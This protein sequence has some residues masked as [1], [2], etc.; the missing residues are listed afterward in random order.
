MTC[1]CETLIRRD[2]VLTTV[3]ASS[4]LAIHWH[5]RNAY[6]LE[7][8]RSFHVDAHGRKH[9]GKLFFAFLLPILQPTN[10]T[11]TSDFVDRL[12]CTCCMAHTC[13]MPEPMSDV[14]NYVSAVGTGN[15]CQTIAAVQW[16][17]PC[18]QF[19]EDLAV[20]QPKS[21]MNLASF[22]ASGCSSL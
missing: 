4:T 1:L 13:E 11:S 19:I 5:T 8:M 10:G 3:L 2:A 21:T 15:S 18:G 12:P 9:N 20:C 6:L 14:S 7:I 22:L 16:V 17:L